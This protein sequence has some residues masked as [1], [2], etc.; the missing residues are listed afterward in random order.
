V[1]NGR[2][3]SQQRGSRR[4]IAVCVRYVND[5]SPARVSRM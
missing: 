1:I 2:A 3:G 5:C 4:W